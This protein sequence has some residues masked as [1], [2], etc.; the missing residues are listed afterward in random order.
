M[1]E[2]SRR[3]RRKNSNDEEEQ[4][5]EEA[6]EEFKSSNNKLE[7]EDCQPVSTICAR[8]LMAPSSGSPVRALIWAPAFDPPTE[9]AL[10]FLWRCAWH[11]AA[12]PQQATVATLG[13]ASS[14]ASNTITCTACFTFT[15]LIYICFVSIHV[16]NDPVEMRK[17]DSFGETRLVRHVPSS[18]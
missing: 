11:A 14:N 4:K 13:S 12:S 5:E 18:S 1:L 15:Y 16:L 10:L 2:R 3:N 7:E 9:L 8:A 17:T 6:Q